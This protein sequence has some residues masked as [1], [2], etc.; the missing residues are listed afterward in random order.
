M[1]AGRSR[2]RR[3]GGCFLDGHIITFIKSVIYHAFVI[4]RARV[5]DLDENT[6]GAAHTRA[7]RL[8]ESSGVQR[9]A[10]VDKLQSCYA[11][12]NAPPIWRW[13]SLG[14]DTLSRRCLI[15]WVPR[16]KTLG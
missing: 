7:S 2:E 13:S 5:V 6:S 16:V 10:G 11:E 4:A 3:C 12:C 8:F 1:V 9:S 14:K 15:Q